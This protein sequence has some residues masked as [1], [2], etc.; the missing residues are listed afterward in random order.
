M[1]PG[2][3]V[4]PVLAAVLLLAL[5]AVAQEPAPT[6]RRAADGPFLGGF[7]K[8]T[9]IVYPLRIGEWDAVGEQRYDAP[10]AGVSVRYQAGGDTSRWVDVYFYPVGVVP[11]SQLDRAARGVVADVAAAVGPG[12]YL[13]VDPGPVRAFRVARRQGDPD[14]LPARSADMRLVREEGAYNSAMALV[15]DRLYHVKARHSVEEARMERA[16]VRGALEAFVVE[17]VARTYIGSTGSC[18]SPVPV[19]ALPAGAPAPADARL[20]L[21]GD[22]EGNGAW[23]ADGRVFAHDPEG[24]VARALALLGMGMEGRLYPG[25][26]GAEPHNPDVPEGHRELRLEYHMPAPAR[27][28]GGWL[29]APARGGLG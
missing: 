3:V 9:R 11:R 22:G 20:A 14:P 5:P 4:V 21:E 17:L 13:E 6:G 10:E 1:N 25:C 23:L 29:H 24:P 28:Q 26:V 12:G 7:L 16:G 15:I 2:H 18:W 27:G 19:E 8:E